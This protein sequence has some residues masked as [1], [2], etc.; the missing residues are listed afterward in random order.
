MKT[1]KYMIYSFYNEKENKYV[2]VFFKPDEYPQRTACRLLTLNSYK[3]NGYKIAGILYVDKEAYLNARL[4]A[5]VE[6]YLEIDH[7][8]QEIRNK[9]KLGL[10][11]DEIAIQS[12]TIAEDTKW[13]CLKTISILI[14][15][16]IDD[17]YTVENEIALALH[18][19]Y[20][21]AIL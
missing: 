13:T 11:S 14:H 21:K 12:L 9:Y 1:G 19:E 7:D 15:R 5:K 8:E 4:T 20:L 6:E 17:D 16:I 10:I 18:D 3:S 2:K